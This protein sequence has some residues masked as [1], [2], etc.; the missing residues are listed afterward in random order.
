LFVGQFGG[1]LILWLGSFHLNDLVALDLS[2][3]MIGERSGT[4]VFQ[5]AKG[6]ARLHCGQFEQAWCRS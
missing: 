3:L 6:D 2:D 1:L 5:F 4:V